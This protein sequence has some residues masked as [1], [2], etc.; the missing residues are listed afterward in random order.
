MR[1]RSPTACAAATVIAAA[2]LAWLYRRIRPRMSR[3]RAA[4]L[5]GTLQAAYTDIRYLG[6]VTR[7]INDREALLGVSICGVL[8]RPAVFLDAHTLEAAV[9]LLGRGLDP[10]QAIGTAGIANN[11]I[12]LECIVPGQQ[13]CRA[14][15]DCCSNCSNSWCCSADN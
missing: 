10:F 9:G 14:V 4:A 13:R 11:K 15:A 7:V 12:F 6:P 3:R 5:L 8:E 1:P 2:W